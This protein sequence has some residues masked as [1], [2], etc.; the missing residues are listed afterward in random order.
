[1]RIIYGGSANAKNTKDYLSINSVD[2]LL[3]GGASL[4]PEFAEMVNFCNNAWSY[5]YINVY[6]DSLDFNKNLSFA[7][8]SFMACLMLKQIILGFGVVLKYVSP[9]QVTLWFLFAKL[10]SPI[11]FLKDYH[12]ELIAIN[13]DPIFL[14]FFN[15]MSNNFSYSIL[16]FLMSF[17]D[18]RKGVTFFFL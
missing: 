13:P 5:S 9:D 7:Y 2:G 1:M 17:M 11:L 6:E 10:N 3:V 12:L 15:L 18:Y 16:Y 14:I 8:Y 4:K